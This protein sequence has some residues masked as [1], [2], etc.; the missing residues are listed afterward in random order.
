[1]KRSLI[2]CY[3]I[4]KADSKR[5]PEIDFFKD[6][7]Y[8]HTGSTQAHIRVILLNYYNSLFLIWGWGCK[9]GKGT[10][11][12]QGH[13]ILKTE[14]CGSLGSASNCRQ[15]IKSLGIHFLSCK[16]HVRKAKLLSN[17]ILCYYR[18][19]T[20]YLIHTTN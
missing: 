16:K 5:Y 18:I 19:G 4:L 2:F 9:D 6:D 10:R 12:A 3:L 14:S 11:M 8:V 13:K 15:V 20:Y 17:K 7:R 1:M